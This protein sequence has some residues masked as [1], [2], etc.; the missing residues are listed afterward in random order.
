MTTT[1]LNCEITQQ[2]YQCILLQLVQEVTSLFDHCSLKGQPLQVFCNMDICFLLKEPWPFQ[3]L[4]HQNNNMLSIYMQCVSQMKA[5]VVWSHNIIHK[6]NLCK[7]WCFVSLYTMVHKLQFHMI[8]LRYLNHHAFADETNFINVTY[9][10]ASWNVFIMCERIQNVTLI[11][12]CL[13]TLHGMNAAPCHVSLPSKPH[14]HT[15]TWE[16]HVITVKWPK[17]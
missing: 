16:N 3:S 8:C 13:K 14:W 2:L 6:G 15:S 1:S 17:L 9:T 12:W 11:W 10:P 5:H 4:N 7:Q